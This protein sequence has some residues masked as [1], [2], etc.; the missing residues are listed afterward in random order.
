MTGARTGCALEEPWLF[1]KD[2]QLLKGSQSLLRY[3][4]AAL[5]T[6]TSGPAC[7]LLAPVPQAVPLEEEVAW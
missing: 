2:G 1:L 4:Q 3:P 5:N 7:A 6:E